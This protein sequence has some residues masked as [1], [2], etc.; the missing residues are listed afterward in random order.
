MGIIGIR[1]TKIMISYEPKINF[2]LTLGISQ[3]F[4]LHIF[5]AVLESLKV[6][7]IVASSSLLMKLF[8]YMVLSLQFFRKSMSY[9]SF[10]PTWLLL[11]VFLDSIVLSDPII[12][13]PCSWL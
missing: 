4:S 7:V 1:I 5:F 10:K 3:K 11:M 6:L 2:G 8:W 13:I 9:K 12:K